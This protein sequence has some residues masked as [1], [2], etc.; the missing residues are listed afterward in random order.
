C[1]ILTGTPPFP[2][3]TS[4]DALR[5]ARAG[6]LAAAFAR[7]DGSGADAEL[8]RLARTCLAPARADRPRD[9]GAVADAVAAYLAS[10]QEGL[11]RAELERVQAEV[12]AVESRKKRRLRW[13]LAAA[14]VGLVAL[15]SGSGWLWHQRRAERDREVLAHLG[16]AERLR[17]QARW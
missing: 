8:V 4:D 14:L 17:D 3:P 15:G 12:Q 10:V 6:E 2:G 9:A 7:L 16:T 11:R 1:V 5:Q 13:T